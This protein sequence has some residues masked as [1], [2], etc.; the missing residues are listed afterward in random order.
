MSKLEIINQALGILGANQ[1]H[2]IDD[3][4]LEAEAGRKMYVTALDSIL[5]E[6]DWNFAI[7][8]VLLNKS[9]KSVAWGGGNYYDLPADLIKICEIKD[10]CCQWKKEGNYILANT[11]DFGITYVSRCTDASLYPSYF[12]EAL[13]VKLAADMCYVLTN[14]SE[15]TNT[16]I[17]MYKGEYLPIA[18]THNAREKSSPVINDGYWVESITGSFWG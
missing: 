3:N 4:T 1:I 5:A 16:I 10:K 18:K 12:K 9:E 8:R 13:A 14:S 6:T 15:K 2:S 7:K 11:A 17:E